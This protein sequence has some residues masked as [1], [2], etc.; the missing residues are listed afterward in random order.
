[1]TNSSVSGVTTMV[2]QT[3]LQYTPITE[4]P[5]RV[6]Q[7]K[8]SFRQ[9]RTQPLQYRLNQLR[10]IYFALSDHANALVDALYR[11]F[12]RA[13]S[14][15]KNMEFAPLM[16][17]LI[18]T[19]SQL[20]RWAQPEPVLLLPVTMRATPVYIERVPLGVVLVISPFNFPLI[21]AMSSII[22]A[23]AAGN[24]VVLKLSEFTPHF[25]L[26]LTLLLTAALDPD[27]FYIVNGAVEETSAVLDLKFDKIM[28]TGLGVVGKI[29]AKKAAETLTPVLLELGGKCPAFVL[30]VK[31]LDLPVVARRIVWGRFINAGQ[32]CVSV[33]YVLVPKALKEKLVKH[34]VAAVEEFY[35]DLTPQHSGYT[36]II[37][38]RAFERLCRVLELTKGTV[39]TGGDTDA[40]TNYIAPT[41]VDNV[42]WLDA[43]ME[44]ELFGP[45]LPVIA[46]ENLAAALDEVVARHDTPLAMYIFTSGTRSRS[47]KDVDLI[48]T[49]VRSGGTMVNDAVTHVGLANAPFGGVGTSGQGLY[50]GYFSYKAFTHER[51]TVEQKLADFAL[52]V[53]YPPYKA[54]KDQ[55]VRQLMLPF[56]GKVWF[57]RKGNV[58]VTG[59]GAIWSMFTGIAGVGSLVYQF[60]S[61]LKL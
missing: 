20:H 14:E 60:G 37:H 28:Y 59:P 22:G 2:T 30:D 13:P 40:S 36:H 42:G 26:L 27:T 39:V 29:V 43:T 23:I 55:I 24:C 53:R 10:N 7:L 5:T 16:N 4:I 18:V 3:E 61:N 34:M 47:N 12:G 38:K 17:E 44:E 8:D 51:T 6:Q 41:I 15:T 32:A 48:R 57:D 1:M 50:H 58:P 9:K 35:P 33:D 31:D 49:T 19:M 11:D 21:L 45:I 46:Y 54:Q 25:A 52:K 56:N